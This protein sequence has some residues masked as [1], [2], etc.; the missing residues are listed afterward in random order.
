MVNKN[1]IYNSGILENDL[2][3]R[4]NVWGTERDGITSK[5]N[6]GAMTDL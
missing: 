4:N 6:K 1:C 5:R 3:G 2:Y